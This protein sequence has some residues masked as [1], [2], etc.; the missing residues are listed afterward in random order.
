ML[1]QMMKRRAAGLTLIELMVAVAIAAVLLAIAAPSF[2]NFILLQRLKGVQAQLVT[3]L[4]YAR[5][6]A[7][8]RGVDVYVAFKT[9]SSMTCYSMYTS[10][11]D[12][13][14]CDCRS[15]AAAACSAV[16][17][18]REIRTVQVAAAQSVAVAASGSSSWFA[19]DH[20]TG[21]MRISTADTGG[22]PP[23]SFVVNTSIDSTRRYRTTVGAA[24]RPTVCAP[25]GSSS[26]LG[27]DAC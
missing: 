17:G 12:A 16:A 25:A 4:Q 18:A 13:T 23:T 19:F 5:S 2:R 20:I 24:G 3:D 7:V 14:Q 15:G 27:V 9:N 6:E 26:G 8:A 10:P 11:T 1:G 22:P 21:A